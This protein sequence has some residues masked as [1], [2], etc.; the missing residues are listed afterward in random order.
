[1]ISHKQFGGPP[2]KHPSLESCL[3]FSF[4]SFLG[5]ASCQSHQSHL[6][7]NVKMWKGAGQEC[8]SLAFPQAT[9]WPAA[10]PD[11]M[12]PWSHACPSLYS[13]FS[14]LPVQKTKFG[15]RYPRIE[16]HVSL[17]GALGTAAS[18]AAGP[19]LAL[20]SCGYTLYD[21]VWRY[22]N[23]F[24]KKIHVSVHTYMYI[25]P[26]TRMPFNKIH[27]KILTSAGLNLGRVKPCKLWKGRG[28]LSNRNEGAYI[29]MSIHV[30][31]LGKQF[32]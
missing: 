20:T 2:K 29:Y 31:F 10:T 11:S 27:K 14:W 5:L 28:C 24:K 13:S 6:A 23:Q 21:D 16:T 3:C 7:Q 25:S 26:F 19:A 22:S 12:P 15:P 32:K 4:L 30:A 18:T 1:M 17:L 8:L 9:H